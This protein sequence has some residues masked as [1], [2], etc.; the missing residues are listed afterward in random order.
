[1]SQLADVLAK[2][3]REQIQKG[4]PFHLL[5]A[6]QQQATPTVASTPSSWTPASTPTP[7]STTL[8][9]PTISRSNSSLSSSATSL[10]SS[11]DSQ[12][13][14]LDDEELGFV[15]EV[16]LRLYNG[17]KHK[18]EDKA[19]VTKPILQLLDALY[20]APYK[21]SLF[22]RQ[23]KNSFKGRKKRQ[24]RK[25]AELDVPLF[26][27]LTR[28]T[29]KRMMQ[30]AENSSS[31][32]YSRY[33]HAA[34]QVVKKR[35]ANHIQSWRVEGIHKPLIYGGQAVYDAKFGSRWQQKDT[36]R[37][38]DVDDSSQHSTP[39][40]QKT[41][42]C[43]SQPKPKP[44]SRRKKQSQTDSVKK[45]LLFEGENISFSQS[46]QGF[47]DDMI[48]DFT[49][50]D[51]DAEGE[52]EQCGNNDDVKVRCEGCK[53]EID[54]AAAFPQ[55]NDWSEQTDEK[56]WCQHCWTE[57]QKQELIPLIRSRQNKKQISKKKVNDEVATSKP[58]KKPAKKPCKC[59]S[60]DHRT[61]RSKCCPLYRGK[62][63]RAVPAIT[64]PADNNDGTTPAGNNNNDE[65]T[66]AGNN[67]NDEN[68]PADTTTAPAEP[69]NPKKRQRQV[70]L[71]TDKCYNVGANVLAN[72]NNKK[73][74]YFAQVIARQGFL[75]DVYFPD[76]AKVKKGLRPC[77]LRPC[78]P[79][80]NCPTRRE[81]I[82]LS[83]VCDGETWKVRMVTTDNNFRCVKLNGGG[84]HNTDDFDIGYVM[85][86]IQKQREEVRQE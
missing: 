32:L 81:M 64:T 13:S 6:L 68:T 15:P 34:K 77:N 74:F 8:V 50:A 29:L 46:K 2:L 9:T 55:T 48:A 12:D 21:S 4:D 54:Q 65:N 33:Y 59:G 47:F 67:N 58:A 82:G 23:F 45:V 71:N 11:A 62:R 60:F 85:R 57:Y 75:H 44:V 63:K 18:P 43:N 22:K 86:T 83:F 42:A 26:R 19:V 31:E 1:M 24:L 79:S 53:K 49:S 17:K 7:T 3:L 56:K 78:P 40:K 39:Q 35:R 52:A 70:I 73:Q 16:G 14:I 25:H 76:D 51:D 30:A 27:K 84:D 66:P 10:S 61:T 80:T 28:V 69:R 38:Y 36:E 5:H 72:F 37:D 20:L 41:P